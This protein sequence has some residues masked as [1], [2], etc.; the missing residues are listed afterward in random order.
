ME[1]K[2]NKGLKI[3]IIIFLLVCLIGIFYFM[4]KMIY[5]E[6]NTSSNNNEDNKTEQK[7]NDESVAFTELA[8]YTFNEGEEKNIAVDGKTIKIKRQNNKYYINEKELEL[9]AEIIASINVTNNIILFEIVPGQF[10][11]TYFVYDLSGNKVEADIEGAQYNNLKLKNGKLCV[12]AFVFKTHWMDG[13]QIGSLMVVPNGSGDCS[14]KLS[15]YP[16]IIEE[17]KDEVL[18]GDYY[19]EYLNNK[20]T[21]KV[22]K[23]K[24]TV[25]ELAKNASNIC[26]EKG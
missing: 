21:L 4:Y 11:T 13:Y 18:E 22:E 2:N 14:K 19:F 1:E 26:V 3:G 23:I 25:A 16:E 8:K 24:L 9:N 7:E 20:L 6:D 15:D 12:D 5:I 10:G 17:Y